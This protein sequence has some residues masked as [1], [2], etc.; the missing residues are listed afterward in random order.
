MPLCWEGTRQANALGQD[1]A[2]RLSEA[3]TRMRGRRRRYCQQSGLHHSPGWLHCQLSPR[4]RFLG[5][6]VAAP[7][8]IFRVSSNGYRKLLSLEA[9]AR[10]SLCVQSGFPAPS[11]SFAVALIGPCHALWEVSGICRPV[12]L[13][14]HQLPDDQ[15]NDLFFVIGGL[16]HIDIRHHVSA[17]RLRTPQ[18]HM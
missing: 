7:L 5:A 14:Q 17:T 3:A 10:K 4:Q 15:V 13:V 12:K 6:N 2:P 9:A 8:V 18:R 1:S 11:G 16:S